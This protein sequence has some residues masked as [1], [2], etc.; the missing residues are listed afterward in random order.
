MSQ[1]KEKENKKKNPMYS[2]SLAM[3]PG[4]KFRMN[5]LSDLIGVLYLYIPRVFDL[6]VSSVT[7]SKVV[8]IEVKLLKIPLKAV[9]IREAFT[10]TTDVLV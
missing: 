9:L 5:T 2:S 1:N 4:D 8:E 3:V 10:G 6:T 7:C